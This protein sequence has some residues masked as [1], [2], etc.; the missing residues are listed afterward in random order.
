MNGW[1]FLLILIQANLFVNFVLKKPYQFSVS[2]Y[3][4]YTI[5]QQ[6]IE[7]YEYLP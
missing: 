3:H 2:A 1:I 7:V 4:G 6:I 5:K